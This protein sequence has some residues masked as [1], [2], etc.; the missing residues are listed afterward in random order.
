MKGT[1]TLLSR[2]ASKGSSH[3]GEDEEE[4]GVHSSRSK[5]CLQLVILVA[6]LDL[7]LELLLTEETDEGSSA[8][9]DNK[10]IHKYPQP[11][12]HASSLNNKT[13]FNPEILFT[14]CPQ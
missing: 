3:K 7:I 14:Q 1:L 6:F 4:N 13:N 8:G 11:S 9:Q 10:E 2:S 12:T 5:E